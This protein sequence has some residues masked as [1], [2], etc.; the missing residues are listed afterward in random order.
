MKL[1][2]IALTVCAASSAGA[3]EREY[4]KDWRTKMAGSV[5]EGY[6]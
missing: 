5:P 2:W 3:V 1:T 6:V 4:L